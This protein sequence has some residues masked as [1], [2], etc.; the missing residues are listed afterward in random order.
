MRSAAMGTLLAF[1]VGAALGE[2]AG[3]A[4][5][6]ATAG[7][8][9]GGGIRALG[10][11]GG[12]KATPGPSPGPAKSA[13]EVVRAG[14]GVREG[15]GGAGGQERAGA[16]L[17]QFRGCGRPAGGE[18]TRSQLL[19]EP[20]R[21]QCDTYSGGR[22]WGEGGARRRRRERLRDRERWRRERWG[23]RQKDSQYS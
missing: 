11:D 22:G 10:P 21:L 12:A 8:W 9:A 5:G 4:R 14:S 20:R 3:G 2:C 19:P 1:V 23:E 15:G 13:S 18:E 7:H 16:R 17:A 6:G